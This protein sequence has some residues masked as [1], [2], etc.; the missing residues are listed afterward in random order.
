MYRGG[1]K[2]SPRSHLWNSIVLTVLIV[3]NYD[4]S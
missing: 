1:P 4:Q 2:L 3:F